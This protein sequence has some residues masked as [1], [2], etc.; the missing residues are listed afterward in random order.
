MNINELLNEVKQIQQKYEEQNRGTGACFNIFSIAHIEHDE[1]II[2]RVIK[3]LIDPRG[4]HYQG[5]VYLR[6]FLEHVLKLDEVLYADVNLDKAVVEREKLISGNRR[7]D[8]FIEIPGRVS[9]PIEVKLYAGDQ[10]AQCSDYYRYAKHFAGEPVM[11][12]L[13]LDRH[14]PSKESMGSLPAKSVCPISFGSEILDWLSACL[15]APETG[16]LAPIR[17]IIRQLM[18]TLCKLTGQM[19]DNME[20]DIVNLLLQSKENMKNADLIAEAAG[21]AC[22]KILDEY[23]REISKRIEAKYPWVEKPLELDDFEDE[24]YAPTGIWY[25]VKKLTGGKYSIALNIT[26]GQWIY[27]GFVSSMKQAVRLSGRSISNRKN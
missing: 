18:N 12:Y 13:T 4:S 17:E 21:K 6:L 15:Q 25:R 19:E 16:S 26:C 27:A 3:E 20:R 22:Q 2:C 24:E 7:I 23:F 1:V 8:I 10:D 5:D 9:I 11:Y 14:M